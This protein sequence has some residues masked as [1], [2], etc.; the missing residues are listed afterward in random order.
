MDA[1]FQD[2]PLSALRESPLNRKH[3]NQTKLDELT[4]S[5]RTK[6]IITPLLVRPRA[7]GTGYD[8]AAGHRRFRAA[9]AAGLAQVPCIV[10]PMSDVEFLEVLTTENL[11]REDVHELEEAEG[12]ALLMKEA[13]YD[14][15]SIASKVGK[16]PSYVY[17]RLKLADLTTPVKLAFLAEKITAG[18]AIQL[19]RLQP[20]QQEEALAWATARQRGNEV[21]SVR[22]LGEF[23]HEHVLLDLKKAPFDANDESLMPAA[24]ACGACPFRA[25]NQQ[26]LFPDVKKGDTCTAPGCYRLKVTAHLERIAAKLQQE[27][28]QKPVRISLA[29]DAYYGEKKAKG[30]LYRGHYPHAYRL[31]DADGCPHAAQAVVF[32]RDRFSDDRIPLGAVVTICREPKCRKGDPHAGRST[33]QRPPRVEQTPAERRKARDAYDT[34]QVG[35]LTLANLNTQIVEHATVVGLDV[36]DAACREL[37]RIIACGLVREMWSDTLKDV[38]RRREWMPEKGAQRGDNDPVSL[39]FYREIGELDGAAVFALCVELAIARSASYGPNFSPCETLDKALEL[40]A[41]AKLLGIDVAGARRAAA[42][43][44]KNDRASW[45]LEEMK[46]A[47]RAK[48]KKKPAAKTV[49][50]RT[51]KAKATRENV[52][53]ASAALP[54]VHALHTEGVA[55][56]LS[57]PCPTCKAAVG[58]PCKRPSGHRVFGGDT[59]AT[60]REA[61]AAHAASTAARPNE[62]ENLDDAFDVSD[63]A[64]REIHDAGVDD[65]RACEICGCLEERARAGGWGWDTDYADVG[66]FVCTTPICGQ[67][68]ALRDKRLAKKNGRTYSGPVSVCD[69]H[70]SAATA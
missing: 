60:R 46:R 68:A 42:A 12:Y 19:A 9:T 62:S 41:I 53:A 38:A 30:V 26:L 65:G 18:H 70:T 27:T 11:Q 45:N 15:P 37:L 48:A 44:V 55:P 21:A 14:V 66:R 64:A 36:V 4:E 23:I 22:A 47:R 35:R 63:A 7:D 29:S 39:R 3:F 8:I 5:V 10:R 51:A 17:Q 20:E 40:K 49:A 56:E 13:G 25:G 34:D 61:I 6:G 52:R 16:S 57:W 59:H 69:L 50:K 28:G 67:Q 2:L 31:I 33:I 32:H 43:K 58:K 1:A 54:D 24:G